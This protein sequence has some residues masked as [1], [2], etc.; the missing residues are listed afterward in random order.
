MTRPDFQFGVPEKHKV[1]TNQIH[2]KYIGKSSSRKLRRVIL[3][4]LYRMDPQKTH[5]K[6]ICCATILK[7]RKLE[8][9]KP[10][11][12]PPNSYRLK[13]GPMY[14]RGLLVQ[15]KSCHEDVHRLTSMLSNVLFWNVQGLQVCDRIGDACRCDG[16]STWSQRNVEVLWFA[17]SSI[18]H[19]TSD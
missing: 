15:A 7:I 4:T 13:A 1:A 9:Q 8:K 12:S 6:N 19:V 14:L 3:Y 18:D 5:Y 2:I 17:W 11:Y 16:C 10:I